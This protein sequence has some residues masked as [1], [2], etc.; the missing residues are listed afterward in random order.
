MPRVQIAT[1]TPWITAAAQDHG[2]HLQAYL[3]DRLQVSQRS[4]RSL[5]RK[6]EA[7][8]WVSCLRQARPQVYRPG[9]LRQV[10][11]RY[12]LAGLQED[13]PWARDF[14]ARFDLPL[15]VSRLAQHAFTELLN[16]AID[17]SGGR[18]VTVSMRQTAMH[19]Q[20]LVSDDGC[21]L[22]QRIGESFDIDDPEL[23]MFELAKGKLTSDAERHTGRGLFFSARLADVMDVHANGTSFQYRGFGRRSWFRNRP[24]GREGTSI[25]LAI[26]LDTP[27]TLDD[28]L[29]AHS[30][31]GR[32]YGFERTAVP[33][34]LIAGPGVGLESR[35]QAR[36]VVHRLSAFA[37]AE[38]DFTG[39]EDVGHGFADELFRV[40]PRQ[41][42]GL[43]LDLRGMAPRVAEMMQSVRQAAA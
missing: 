40:C 23:A 37:A 25:Y 12:D 18:R 29:R 24:I 22:F 2:P 35:A 38:L 1:V 43:Q 41:W 6:L 27:R 20:L 8:G 15:Q 33:L 13:R 11:Q 30:A 3:A 32:G 4:A 21:G 9:P 36:R 5:L 42:P 26:A 34:Q 16:N 39:I 31:D 28:V 7:S 19:V 10:V 17:H 14:A